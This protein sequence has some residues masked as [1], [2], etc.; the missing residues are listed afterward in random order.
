VRESEHGHGKVPEVVEHP[1]RQADT[2]EACPRT[3]RLWKTMRQTNARGA[4]KMHLT[5]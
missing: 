2:T 1:T 5:S 3:L 4:R